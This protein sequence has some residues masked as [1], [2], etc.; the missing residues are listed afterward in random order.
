VPAE[1]PQAPALS[2]RSSS[3]PSPPKNKVQKRVTFLDAK[4]I[5]AKTPPQPRKSPHRH[6]KNTTPKHAF[7]AKTPAKTP[8]HHQN[9]KSCTKTKK[10]RSG[11]SRT[12]HF[13]LNPTYME[14]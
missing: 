5:T 10:E 8:L 14:A 1:T 12:A 9:K 2:A 6:H 13:F 4:N 11:N 3:S 7:C